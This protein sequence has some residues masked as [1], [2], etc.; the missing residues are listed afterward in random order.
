MKVIWKVFSLVAATHTDSGCGIEILV[1]STD[2]FSISEKEFATEE[3]AII[4]LSK[5]GSS[6]PD[7]PAS[8]FEIKK[9]FVL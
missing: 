9:V 3:A 8:L 5:Q 7:F 6:H 2:N 1:S 4:E